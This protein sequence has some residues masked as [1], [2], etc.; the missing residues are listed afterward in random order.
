MNLK[1]IINLGTSRQSFSSANRTRT[2][3]IIGLIT[4][5]ISLLYSINYIFFLE[6]HTVGFINLIFTV[7]YL[8]TIAFSATHHPKLAK[9]WFFSVLMVHLLIC[10]NVYVTNA[11]GFH[12]YFFLVP[13][14]VFLLFELR[15]R[16][17]Q[18]SLSLIALVLFFY[19]ENTFNT[20][21]LI[22]LT[23]QMNHMLYQSVVFVTMLEVIFVLY[24]FAKQIDKNEQ[25]LILQAT[26][27]SLT[28][29]ANRH[30]FFEE[31]KVLFENAVDNKL[32]FT[33][34]LLDLDFFKKINDQYGHLVGDKCLIEVTSTIK[35][36]CREHDL[37]ARIGGEEFV[38][39]MP[40]TSLADAQ[41]VAERM[42]K[43]IE[44]CK[45]SL[46]EAHQL[47]CTAS[48]GLADKT[49]CATELKDLLIR[50]D[51]ALYVAKENGRNCVKPYCEQAA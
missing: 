34:M 29:L 50:A 15:E 35:A 43:H 39:A 23:E 17:E 16:V 19:C 3:N 22:V 33:L 36:L 26:T 9:I 30:Y 8:F 51:K 12:L 28:R 38:V 11:S 21:P 10:T 18:V 44:D 42:R 6:N 31:G 4:V 32:P 37:C 25:Q 1:N 49:Q 20:E 46:S 7:A 40:N 2:M 41:K 45:I 13:T 14:G 27:D 5:V 48:F 24:I 47:T